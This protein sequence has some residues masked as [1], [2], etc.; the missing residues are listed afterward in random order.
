MSKSSVG[1][2]TEALKSNAILR[3]C[4]HLLSPKPLNTNPKRLNPSKTLRPKPETLGSPSIVEVASPKT[5]GA[6]RVGTL[7]LKG[8]LYWY[9]KA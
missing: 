6:H 3:P 1:M 9:F 5:P 4:K 8:S 2:Q 7:A